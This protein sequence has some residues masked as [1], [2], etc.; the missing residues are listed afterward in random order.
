[1][2]RCLQDTTGHQPIMYRRSFLA[3]LTCCGGLFVVSSGGLAAS[4]HPVRHP[5]VIGFMTDFN[6]LDDAV[7]LCKGV[8]LSIAPDAQIVDITHQVT[9]FSIADGARYLLRAAE[10]F[11]ADAVF[12]VVIDPGVGTDRAPIIARS[13]RGQYFVLPNNGLLTLVQDRIGIIG[14]RAI[15]NPEWMLS[16][17]S[18]TF[19][20]RDV[21]SPA[22]AHLARGENWEA[23]GPV[24]PD[25]VRLDLKQASSGVDGL[26]A[27]VVA[28]D[29]P[30]GN[31][32]TN[33]SRQAF[34]EL[35]YRLGDVVHLKVG[36]QAFE[37]PYVRTFGEVPIGAPLLYI[38]SSDLVSVAINQDN[39]ARVHGITPPATLELSKKP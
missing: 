27:S 31:L 19:H 30:F 11:P 14:A 20:G 9:P 34:E 7:G 13:K 18:N 15:T 38:D 12:V 17:V 21:F 6:T 5:P 29:G 1:M 23:A 36:S 33:V 4:G 32:I 28:L 26:A 2:R 10:Y 16:S 3:L 35:G 8:M 37:M 39:F 25:L 24:V 22:G